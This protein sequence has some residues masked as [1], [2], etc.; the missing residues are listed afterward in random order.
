MS[1]NRHVFTAGGEGFDSPHTVGAKAVPA[2]FNIG[3]TIL[4][5]RFRFNMGG[6][7]VLSARLNVETARSERKRPEF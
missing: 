2:P 5:T 4:D 6:R 3:T 1:L 7:F